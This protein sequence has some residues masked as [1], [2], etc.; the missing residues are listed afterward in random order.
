MALTNQFP[1]PEQIKV[2]RDQYL[3]NSTPPFTVNPKINWPL[4]DTGKLITTPSELLKAAAEHNTQEAIRLEVQI[5]TAEEALERL[6]ADAA[7]FRKRAEQFTIA[8]NLQSHFV[9]ES[10]GN[11]P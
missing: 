2:L 3:I 9:D 4:P 5:R 10:N 7:T 8:A 6:R 1:T 11:N